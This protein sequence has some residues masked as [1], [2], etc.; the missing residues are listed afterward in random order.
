MYLSEF[1]VCSLI[2]LVCV[3]VESEHCEE[4]FYCTY[5]FRIIRKWFEPL[6]KVFLQ[7][8]FSLNDS[9]FLFSLINTSVRFDMIITRSFLVFPSLILPSLFLFF[10]YT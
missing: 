9:T 3:K 10:H 6:V 5:F 8:S 4:G 7:H 1:S 2:E